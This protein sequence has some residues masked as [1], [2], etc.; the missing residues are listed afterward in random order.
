MNARK[1]PGLEPRRF[2]DFRREL[3]AR[4]RVWLPAWGFEDNEGD[5]GRA[6]LEV[7]ARLSAEV[8]ERL[9]RGGDK[10][11]RAFLDWLGV[12]GAAARPA[13]VPVVFKLADTALE[14]VP[15]PP[16]VRMQTDVRDA[17]VTFETQADVCIVPGRTDAVIAVDP[18]ADAFY[19]APPGLG[20]PAPRPP[21]PDRW[22]LKSFAGPQ[23]NTLQLDAPADLAP[24]MIVAIGGTQYRIASAKDDLVGID[25]PL[26]TGDGLAAGTD[27][28]RVDA[29]APFD[30]ARNQQQHLL[31]LGHADLLNIEADAVIDVVGAQTLGAGVTWEIWSKA[32]PAKDTQGDVGERVDDAA[33]RSDWRELKPAETQ[34]EDALV[35]VKQAGEVE[36]LQLG[37]AQARWIRARVA[38]LEGAM[39]SLTAN[40]IALR[41]NA[42]PQNNIAVPFGSPVDGASAQPQVEVMVNSTPDTP[43]GFYP[44]GREPRMFDTLY[45][46]CAEAFSKK[47]A[48]ATVAFDLADGRFVSFSAI[49]AGAIGRVL[50]GVDKAGALHLYTLCEDTRTGTL[51]AVRLREPVM[52]PGR[53]VNPAPM[54]FPPVMW[55]EGDTL[56]VALAASGQ[57]FVLA[58]IRPDGTSKDWLALGAPPHPNQ[59]DAPVTGL[60]TVSAS[61][62]LGVRGSATLVALR[63][64]RLYQL[65]PVESET[66]SRVGD[67]ALHVQS[68]AQVRHELSDTLPEHFLAIV[69][70]AA[71][72]LSLQA[73]DASGKLQSM[74]TG[75]EP[76]VVPFGMQRSGG[77]LLAVAASTD[78][79]A[80]SATTQGGDPTSA[81]LPEPYRLTGGA[82]D[83]AVENGQVTVRGVLR[84]S[85]ADADAADTALL[86]WRPSDPKYGGIVFAS[87]CDAGVGLPAGHVAALTDLALMPGANEATVLAARY[88]AAAPPLTAPVKAFVSALAVPH[89]A[90]ALDAGDTIVSLVAKSRHWA[91]LAD[92]VPVIG[93]GRH[94]S[95]HFFLLDKS[96]PEPSH[97]DGLLLARTASQPFAG[98]YSDPSASGPFKNMTLDNDDADLPEVPFWL[99][100]ARDG[101]NTRPLGAFEVET[102]SENR[103]AVLRQPLPAPSGNKKLV[104]WHA[105]P[106][107]ANLHPA[108]RLDSSNNQ[109][110]LTALTHG[111]LYFPDLVPTR[112]VVSALASSDEQPPLPRWLALDAAWDVKPAPA[113]AAVSFLVDGTLSDWVQVLGD[114]SSNPALSWEYWNGTGWWRLPLT[115]EDTGNLRNSGPVRFVVQSDLAPLAWA[116]RTNYWI[117]TRLVGGDFGKETVTVLTRP[118]LL[119]DGT[120]QT[121]TR[122]T[123]GV[124]APFATDI[125][126]S[127]EVNQPALPTFV[128]TQDSGNLRDQSDANRAKDASVD[129]FT[130]LAYTLR[131][132]DRA[133]ITPEPGS[134]D[135][136]CCGGCAGGSHDP[137][138]D[139]SRRCAPQAGA[140]GMSGPEDTPAQ[141]DARGDRRALF[142]GVNG[143]LSG[144]PVNILMRVE[145][146]RP[147]DAFA[148]LAF[149]AL[150]GG[151]FT[152]LIASDETRALGESGIVSMSLAVMP[153]PAELF[154]RSLSWVRLTPATAAGA[155]RPS[156]R[157]VYLNAAWAL[158]AETLTRE[159][160]GSSQ[161]APG[162]ALQLARPPLLRDSLEL[163]VREP[164]GDEDREALLRD[165]SQ[166]V[167]SA[168]PNLPGDWVLWTAVPDPADCD[169]QARVYALDEDTG[170]IT[171]GDG[172]HGMIPPIG[173]GSIVA[174][175]YQRTE[176]ATD[177]VVPANQVVAGAPLNLVTPI[178]NVES[179]IA[180]DQSAGGVAP[181]DAGRVLRF[182][183]ARLRHRGR[184]LS[185]RDFEDLALEWFPDIAQA[186]C[187]V[188]RGSVRLVVVMR[189]D[190]VAPPRAKLRELR[191]ALLEV[192]PG[193]IGAAGAL[194]IE[195]PVPRR[196]RVK[197]TLRAATLDVTGRLA[198]WVKRRL[199]TCFDPSADDA[200][201]WPL[202]SSPSEDDIAG[203]LL[204]APD[205]RG[206]VASALF[207][208]DGEGDETPW[209]LSLAPDELAL[210][211]DDG[212]RIAFDI[213]EAVE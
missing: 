110:P 94:A 7:A 96:L 158:A 41:I 134:S 161:G 146:E 32:K 55:T 141:A 28:V 164:L 74:L 198:T 33:A 111:A 137:A 166:R 29:F 148:P 82:L 95:E 15:A 125:R 194:R 118:A 101:A 140:P 205:L 170:V 113:A 153:T 142:V 53:S 102:V 76:A 91:R 42:T 159:L 21:T 212:V 145:E 87:T 157:G 119:G 83:G 60:V 12:R 43:R 173:E 66:W 40:G 4:A 122:T 177:G 34:R 206:I 120:V 79:R 18:A 48:L 80:L 100:I 85:D 189:G 26:Q 201:P 1:P 36:P 121:V 188:E 63:D 185:A 163:R 123:E 149:D 213:V 193:W 14:P 127:Y 50:A 105:A 154:G 210:I 59:P 115:Q 124:R 156:L 167:K 143:R 64:G 208:V 112:Q 99:V 155:W 186:R 107:A 202:G 62:A 9:D 191:R 103:V 152:P 84:S 10:L 72:G 178:E 132:I 204:D 27:V 116:G 97:A 207:E 88:T 24:G 2:D 172:L 165:D 192:A 38:H 209:P 169:A 117:R 25:P 168:E 70:D 176:P 182:G 67:E 104:Y 129:V 58:G 135:G 61:H 13:R 3:F 47:G 45:I 49:H 52:P 211:A 183:A 75:I 138:Q 151:R 190:T 37:G 20:D 54:S 160:V 30:G 90:P 19:L 195:G 180:A 78:G 51:T 22:R 81:K 68:I 6:L 98:A 44:L 114:T 136:A 23:A 203:M 196:L 147:H 108:L 197:L 162:L 171:F 174:F 144:E 133:G 39:P 5:F 57:V 109:W 65:V 17:T 199:R 150:A 31:Y 184:A 71:D 56:S 187:V 130:P 200:S 175:A 86:S 73:A 106:L 128:L 92:A 11:S 77:E 46:G 69:D 131:Q 16:P 126:V 35:L 139:L 181:E 89:P 8:A 93:R 179:A